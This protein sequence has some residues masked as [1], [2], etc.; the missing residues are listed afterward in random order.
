LHLNRSVIVTENEAGEKVDV[1]RIDN[2]PFALADALRDAGEAP[3]VTIE[4]TL[5]GG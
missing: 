4:A 5:L 2:D 3:E 1:T